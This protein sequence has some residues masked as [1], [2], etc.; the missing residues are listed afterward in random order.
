VGFYVLFA[1]IVLARGGFRGVP[2]PNGVLRWGTWVLVGLM[3]LGVL[4]NLASSS[5]WERFGWEPLALILA[6]LCLFVALKRF[7]KRLVLS[8]RTAPSAFS[9]QRAQL[10]G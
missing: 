1:L 2:L 8:L 6:L 3:F 4:P 10:F 5:G 9:D 7:A